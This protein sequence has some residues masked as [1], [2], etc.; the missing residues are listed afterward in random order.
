MKREE[1]KNEFNK[2]LKN[3]KVSEELKEKTIN[4]IYL[5]G[6]VYHLPYWIKNCAAVFIVTCLCLSIY[7]VNNKNIF[8][9]STADNENSI[10]LYSENYSLRSINKEN[11]ELNDEILDSY[12]QN[13]FGMAITENA[14][15]ELFS[16]KSNSIQ[17]SINLDYD[18]KITEEEFLLNNPNAIKIENGYILKVDNIEIFYELKD[19]LVYKKAD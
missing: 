15:K 17:D 9:K 10:D 5:K 11:V 12:N 1:L 13:S 2:K 16:T 8:N 18:L 3:I 14:T 19:G 6:N 7:V 4:K